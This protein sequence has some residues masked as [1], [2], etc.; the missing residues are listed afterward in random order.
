[1][2]TGNK[3]LV[4]KDKVF[5]ITTRLEEI[6]IKNQK[7]ILL[8]DWCINFT[9][10]KNESKDFVFKQ[11]F[12]ENAVVG[13]IDYCNVLYDKI[14]IAITSIFNRMFDLNKGSN[15]YHILIG[16]W[17]LHFLH[18][19]YD[20]YQSLKKF[21]SIYPNFDTYFL[22][23]NQYTV[24]FDYCD[25]MSLC[26]TDSY[27]L[28]IFSELLKNMGYSFPEK[29]INL[30][31][32][33]KISNKMSYKQKIAFNLMSLYNYSINLIYK[34]NNKILFAVPYFKYNKLKSFINLLYNSKGKLMIDNFYCQ[35]DLDYS[36]DNALRNQIKFSLS[37]NE[38]EKIICAIIKKNI[39]LVFIEYFNFFRKK[40]LINE[41]KDVKIIFSQNSIHDNLLFKH[42]CAENQ[43]NLLLLFMQ[44]G[45]G[46]FIDKR[47]LLEE[48]ELSICDI[49]YSIGSS[50][51]N[52]IKSLPMPELGKKI[53]QNFSNKN[54][55]LILNTPSRYLYRYHFQLNTYNYLLT[56]DKSILFLK[57][58]NND[59]KKII[60]FYPNDQTGWQVKERFLSAKV[61]FYEYPSNEK[62]DKCLSE[63]YICVFDNFTTTFLEAIS[64]KIPVVIYLDK[65]I[66][67]FR[68]SAQSYFDMLERVK[69]LHY[70]PA[71]ASEH[72]N[73]IYDDVNKWWLCPK[74]QDARLKFVNQYARTSDNWVEEWLG[75]FEKVVKEN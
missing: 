11:Q 53:S 46:Y 9:K 34:N 27:N 47:H 1:M 62:F 52:I 10:S 22:D 38:F 74:V 72:V 75:E 71:S 48:Y 54:I 64:L 36:I 65:S 73:K 50:N 35:Y 33:C 41:F 32:R 55:V 3:I 31:K 4:N 44:H 2:L 42:Y 7:K 12:E 13:A 45:N 49:Y 20:R 69:I 26:N 29:T 40:S 19:Y 67:S 17:L 66:H 56:I 39:P 6:V 37:D 5:L 68:E 51:T 14:L 43:Q 63:S 59:I 15:F 24:P 61:K 21:I 70:S 30:F 58:L 18:I 16:N 60:R 57:L 23:A 8:G 25:F 28:Q